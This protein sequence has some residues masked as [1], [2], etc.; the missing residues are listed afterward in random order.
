MFAGNHKACGE[1]MSGITLKKSTIYS[2]IGALLVLVAAA[3]LL[4]GTPIASAAPSPTQDELEARFL[5]LSNSHSS[6]CRGPDFIDEKH[7][8]EYLQ[9]SCCSAMDLHR[10][11]EQ[12]RGLEKYA[13][14]E[15]IPSDPYN[16]S[17]AHARQL[18]GYQQTI[19]LDAVQQ[20]VYDEAVALSHE[21]GPCCCKCWRWYAFEGLAKYL[22]VEYH[23]TA[24]QVADVWDLEDGCGGT[25]HVEEMHA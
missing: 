6:L 21:G 9:G 22:I 14:I 8:E 5:S 23:F 18:L 20:A 2:L 11:I 24:E 15:E 4:F 3:W 13:Y 12:V 1:K 19:Q 7:E 10:Y 16:I 25:G 17:V